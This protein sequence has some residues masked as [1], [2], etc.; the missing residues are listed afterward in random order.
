MI[1]SEVKEEILLIVFSII[2]IIIIIILL[3]G[4]FTWIGEKLSEYLVI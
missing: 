1:V 2:A 4:T 3:F